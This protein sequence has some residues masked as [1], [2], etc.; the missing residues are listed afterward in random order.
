MIEIDGAYLE[1]GGQIVRTAIGLS[2]AT[3]IPCRIRDIRKGRRRPGLAAQHLCGVRAVAQ[4]CGA[5]VEGGKLRSMGLT[6]RPGPL[7]PP[8]QIR[9]DVGT[10]GAVTLVLQALLIPLAVA[11]RPTEVTVTGGTHVLWAPTTDYLHHVTAWFLARMDMRV[12]FLDMRPG[13]YPKGGGRVTLRTAPG[14]LEPLDLTERGERAGVSVLSLASQDLSRAQVAER[15]IE[16]VYGVLNATRESFD[17]SPTRSPGTAVLLTA[18]FENCRLGA[19]NLGERGRRAEK[20]GRECAQELDRLM[21][22]GSCLDPHM[23]DQVLP[24]LA[25]AGGESQ[26]RVAEVTDH[27]R[28]NIRVIEQFLP[29]RFAV[30]EGEALITCRDGAG[31]LRG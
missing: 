6:F 7:D 11:T 27:C 26:V 24:F 28:T 25:L 8:E 5:R 4:A 18:E 17:Y 29:A 20:V 12:D 14:R 16:G 22:T 2:A 13:F 23:A 19:S 3:G 15:Q 30:D 9:V 31:R 21:K 1:G 10:A